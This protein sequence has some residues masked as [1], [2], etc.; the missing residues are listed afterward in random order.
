V[1]QLD[2]HVCAPADDTIDVAMASP[3]TPTITNRIVDSSL[4]PIAFAVRRVLTTVR[5]QI[6]QGG[7]EKEQRACRASRGRR[8]VRPRSADPDD[9]AGGAERFDLPS[10]A[11][12]T[13]R[14]RRLDDLPH[15]TITEDEYR[16]LRARELEREMDRR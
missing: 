4:L 12:L 6:R 2:L 7:L 5:A 14:L 1:P 13:E 15:P 9:A 8:G 3:N 11:D 10:D 16:T